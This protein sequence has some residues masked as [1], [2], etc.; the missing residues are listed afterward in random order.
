MVRYDLG[1]TT[2]YRYLSNCTNSLFL[3]NI[4]LLDLIVLLR[5][6]QVV[7]WQRVM[8]IDEKLVQ[9]GLT[10][11]LYLACSVFTF[12]FSVPG[13]MH[14]DLERAWSTEKNSTDLP[15]EICMKRML[16]SNILVMDAL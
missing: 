15:L 8:E 4:F 3:V 9:V 6:I 12:I 11:T 14:Y 5:Y 7:V 10:A 16:K 13:K 2:A 1:N